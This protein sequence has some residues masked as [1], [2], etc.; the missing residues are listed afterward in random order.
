[1]E[2]R[3]VSQ[4]V[5]PWTRF[6][7]ERLVG[8]SKYEGSIMMPKH[9]DSTENNSVT[10]TGYGIGLPGPENGIPEEKELCPFMLISGSLPDP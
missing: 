2:K 7:F 3:A 9:W 8:K 10:E 5:S 4:R 1:M 6:S